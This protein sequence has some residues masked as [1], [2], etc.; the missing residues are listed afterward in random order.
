VKFLLAII[1]SWDGNA[2]GCCHPDIVN[3]TVDGKKIYS[4]SFTNFPSTEHKASYP[5]SNTPAGVILAQQQLLGFYSDFA[6]SAYNMGLEPLLNNIPHTASTLTIEWYASGRGWQGGDDESWAIDN[7]EVSVIPPPALHATP[8]APDRIQLGWSGVPGSK[9]YRLQRKSGDCSSASPWA[10]RV[11]RS[12][13]HT[14]F[15]D[16]SLKP[17]TAYAYQIAAYY[18]GKSFSPYSA[19]ASATTLAA[20]TPN[21]PSAMNWPYPDRT[22]AASASATRVTLAWDDNADDETS[23]ALWRKAGSGGWAQID[24]APANT[25]QYIDNGAAGNQDTTAYAYDV[26]ACN[27]KGCSAAN[28]MSVPFAPTDLSAT[29]AKAVNLAWHDASDNETG[30]EVFRKSGR[31]G[32]AKPWTQVASLAAGARSHKDGSAVSGQIYAYR[33]RAVYDNGLEP[34]TK[35]YSGYSGCVSATAP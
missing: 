30:F 15:A 2:L 28:P 10:T 1:D 21:M 18:G 9:S 32:S 16:S 19:C 3:V 7:V 26:R 12:A 31:C 34:R 23:F 33:V 29:V 4:E 14:D 25:Q 8:V 35:G 13:G 24:T 22:S 5:K 17:G 27:A 11:E 20:G 6:D